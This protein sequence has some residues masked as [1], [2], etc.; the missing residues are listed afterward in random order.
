M[1]TVRRA[2]A[3]DAGAIAAL[4]SRSETEASRYRGHIDAD[5][6]AVVSVVAL[7]ADEVVG[8]VSFH[9]DGSVRTV[10]FVHVHENARGVGVGDALMAWVLDDAR[11]VGCSHIRST[12]LPGDRATKNLFERNGLVAR[13]IQVE[14]R[15]D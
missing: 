13:A 14:S 1:I 3:S 4:R 12:A 5:H 2:V 8:A 7:I 15:L 10:S 11:N 9:D 6:H